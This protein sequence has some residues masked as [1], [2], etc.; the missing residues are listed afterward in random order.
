M[1]ALER[2][3][4]I[5]AANGVAPRKL[6]D[7]WVNRPQ[8]RPHERALWHQFMR[9]ARFCAGE[10]RAADMLAWFDMCGVAFEEREWL[11]DVFG[12]LA[13]VSRERITPEE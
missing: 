11:A 6:H 4:E 7:E 12:A 13:T 5:R 1:E 3:N 2:E 8:L 9:F 10:P